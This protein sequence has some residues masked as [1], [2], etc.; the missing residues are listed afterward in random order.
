M[1]DRPQN[2]P[3]DEWPPAWLRMEVCNL[4]DNPGYILMHDHE[5]AAAGYPVSQ[6]EMRDLIRSRHPGEVCPTCGVIVT[7]ADDTA[8]CDHADCIIKKWA[9][10]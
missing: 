9:T 2:T 6:D 5:K 4:L 10:N 8:P 1:K 7:R 3:L